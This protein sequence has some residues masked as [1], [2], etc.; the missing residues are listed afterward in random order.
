MGASR[1]EEWATRTKKKRKKKRKKKE[2]ERAEAFFDLLFSLATL[3]VSEELFG[4]F[5]LVCW[6]ERTRS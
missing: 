4:G 2:E 1:G 3:A 6:R 5:C